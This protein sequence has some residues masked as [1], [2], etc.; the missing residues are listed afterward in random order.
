MVSHLR[1]H[2]CTSAIRSRYPL[3]TKYTPPDSHSGSNTS[4]SYESTP[5]PTL[6]PAPDNALLITNPSHLTDSQ[7]SHYEHPQPPEKHDTEISKYTNIINLSGKK[8]SHHAQSVLS[9]GLSF[10]PTPCIQNTSRTL[11]KDLEEFEGKYVNT[12]LERVPYRAKRILKN[13]MIKIRS[14]LYRCSTVQCGPNLSTGERQ[15]LCQLAKDDS[16]VISKSDKGDLVVI[17][18]TTRYLELAFEHLSDR[19]TYQLIQNDPTEQI[20]T[21]FTEY[22]KTCK[23]RG[24]ITTQEYYKL[25]P[26]KKVDTQ[27]IY[28]LPKV[29][30]NPLKLR[31]IVSCT[32]GPTQK[33][34]AFLD[35]LLQPQMKKVRSYLKSSTDL[36]H[37]L[38]SLT[39]PVHAYLITLDIESLYTNISHEEAIISFL[40]KFKHHPRKVFLL[41]LLKYVLKNNV[42][43][44]DNLI[45]TQLC[46]VAM[47]TRLAPALA[48]IYIGDLEEDY[49]QTRQKKPFLWVRYIDDIFT[50][51]THSLEDFEDFFENLNLVNPKIHFTAKT[52]S[53]ACDF[54]DL[55]VY[56][57]PEFASTGKLSTKIYYKPW[58]T[59]SFPLGS[60]YMPHS[61]HKGI[62]IGELTRLIRN[63]TSPVLFK[64]YKKKL[65]NQF[66]HRKY[67]KNIIK[68]L[69]KMNHTI[70]QS[71]LKT[72][73][74]RYMERPLPFTTKFNIYKPS[75][76]KIIR[77]RWNA[78]Y[79]NK[80]LFP[81][82]P[83]SPFMAYKN[84]KTLKAILSYKRRLFNSTPNQSNLQQKNAVRFEYL[85]F[86][87][88]RSVMP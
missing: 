56:K 16:L 6:S 43:Q 3:L 59:F 63:T 2:T 83:N 49:I 77:N 33:A 72:R 76:Q 67:A 84:H 31:P 35:K 45:F 68:I 34:S 23:D 78:I 47:G 30:R 21:Q 5:S 74:T 20:V 7:L 27:R 86:N 82:F 24:V 25:A 22:L 51:W 40:R 70:R 12:W 9:K 79:D 19:K 52:N 37:I 64:Y 8:L 54:L 1:S 55:T 60:S 61:I 26:T 58:N 10:I 62:A 17:L 50:I 41:D 14:D 42:F 28:F 80:H 71:L 39:I 81:L 69:K 88:P 4:G 48:T 66:R 53:Q 32:N 15:A 38:Q 29:H 46:G 13:T 36:I 44:F 57:G 87:H 18:S 65:I 75:L 73:K 85:K 11:S